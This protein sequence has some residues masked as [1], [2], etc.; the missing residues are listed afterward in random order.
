MIINSYWPLL[1]NFQ[2]YSEL[3]HLTSTDLDELQ[4]Q[5]S[6]FRNNP[7]WIERQIRFITDFY[8][9]KNNLH[10]IFYTDPYPD[11]QFSNQY[12]KMGQSN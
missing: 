8:Q 6:S 11:Q 5:L 4:P 7:F 2:F 1:K 10:L 12:V 3:W 9:D